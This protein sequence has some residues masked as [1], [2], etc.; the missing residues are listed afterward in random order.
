MLVRP[1]WALGMSGS[2][3]RACGSRNATSYRYDDGVNHVSHTVSSALRGRYL[4][5]HWKWG[6]TPRTSKKEPRELFFC[7][8]FRDGYNRGVLCRRTRNLS[9]GLGMC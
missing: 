4:G 7:L 8:S 6:F 9:Y 3:V 5:F 1:I 2:T